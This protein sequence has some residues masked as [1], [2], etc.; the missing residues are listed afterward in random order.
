[1]SAAEQAEFRAELRGTARGFLAR[2]C[3]PAVVRAIGEGADDGA[4]LRAAVA[5]LGWYGAEVPEAHG[6]LGGAPADL[7][8]LL[9]ECGRALAPLPLLGTAVLGIGALLEAPPALQEEWLGRAAAGEAV[10][11]AALGGPD[12]VPGVLDVSAR[13]AAGGGAVLDGEAGFVCD[14][15]EADAV[16]VAAA[17]DGGTGL[18]CVPAGAG[19]VTIERQRAH[20][21]TRSLGRLRLAGVEVD[22][23]RRI[24][25]PGGARALAE[26]LADRGALAV[27]ADCVGGAE[28][29][30]EI[31]LEPLR[32]REQ[33]G[34]P[35]GSFQALKHRCA[36]MF[37]ALTGARTAVEH[38]ALAIERD[39]ERPAA[40][41][42]AK[43]WASEAYVHIASE[44][45]QMHGGIGFT[46]EHDMHLHVKRA[47]LA[48]VL[49]GDPAW[50]RDR[51]GRMILPG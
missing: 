49:F 19:G 45:V 41:S 5:E 7:V 36:D 48:E 50:H 46:W 15:P 44:G 27:A 10:V 22:A 11:T 35:I 29:V 6:G 2:R 12:G 37:L 28:R 40:V 33:F 31:T 39:D 32:T 47:K 20:D 24:G 4:A 8:V 3:P 30:L 16:V 38:A 18:F 42:I 17:E 14:L 21:R 51:L 34:R 25:E 1:M 23:E 26:R 13:A 43:S 9:E